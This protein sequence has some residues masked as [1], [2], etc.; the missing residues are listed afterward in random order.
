[1]ASTKQEKMI[2]AI[3]EQQAH[4][5]TLA[6]KVMENSMK[7]FELN[8]RM[9][10]ESIGDSS[11]SFQRLLKGKPEDVW[12]VDSEKMQTKMTRMMDY[13]KEMNAIA[14][15]F[16]SDLYQM[17]QTQ[18]QESYEKA[19]QL[20]EKARPAS[21]STKN[22]QQQPFDFVLAAFGDASKGYEQ[23][24]DV[25]RKIADAV[26]HNLQSPT[27]APTQAS[28]ESAPTRKRVHH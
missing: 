1:M 28:T 19:S 20:V 16:N 12:K 3:Q 24:M 14:A 27:Q 7:L 26:E 9:V 4:W 15:E 23:W 10:K 21:A 25:S 11:D 18:Y 17:G 22:S 6:S 13:A 5:L 8:A 2:D